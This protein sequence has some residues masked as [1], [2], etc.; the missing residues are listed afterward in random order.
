MYILKWSFELLS[1]KDSIPNRCISVNM[2]SSEW[3]ASVET[4]TRCSSTVAIYILL[5][6]FTL[7]LRLFLPF[8]LSKKAA[9]ISCHIKN[10]DLWRI[11][12]FIMFR[13]SLFQFWVNQQEH[14]RKDVRNEWKLSILA[15]VLI[16][17]LLIPH[18]MR[19]RPLLPKREYEFMTP[20]VPFRLLP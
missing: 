13:A 10:N 2:W 14:K 7:L 1:I 4:H 9:Y 19:W 3:Y 8:L 11:G 12:T 16:Q 15:V 5:S 17:N 20:L 6:S 18:L